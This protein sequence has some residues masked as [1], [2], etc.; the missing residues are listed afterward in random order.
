M[1]GKKMCCWEQNH[2]HLITFYQTM[3]D[4]NLQ[5][6]P[7]AAK[8]AQGAGYTHTEDYLVCKAF[9]AASEDPFVG[10]SQKG[11]DLKRR[12]TRSIRS[13][14]LSRFIWTSWSILESPCNPVAIMS[15]W[16]VCWSSLALHDRSENRISIE[17]LQRHNWHPFLMPPA[18]S[19]ISFA[20]W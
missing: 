13:F 12:C 1:C 14:F 15:K 10:T 20:A 5:A 19:H 6:P 17:G 3:A 11:K 2:Q 9:I 18:T 4:D 7:A 16:S 8:K